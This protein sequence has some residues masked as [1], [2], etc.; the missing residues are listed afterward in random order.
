MT[1]QDKAL[2]ELLERQRKAMEPAIRLM[3]RHIEKAA[4]IS[5]LLFKEEKR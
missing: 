5:R 4:E 2:S 3:S 1:P